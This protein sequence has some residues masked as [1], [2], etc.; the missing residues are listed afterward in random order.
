MVGWTMMDVGLEI[1]E[2]FGDK[3]KDRLGKLGY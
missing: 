1:G 3:T 2:Y